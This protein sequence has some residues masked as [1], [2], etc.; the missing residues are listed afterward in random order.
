MYLGVAILPRILALHT[1]DSAF[2]RRSITQYSAVEL[3]AGTNEP[4]KA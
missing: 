4:F 3:H 1:V 2:N